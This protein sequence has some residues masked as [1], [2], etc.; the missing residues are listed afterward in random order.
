MV[1]SLFPYNLPVKVITEFQGRFL[2]YISYVCSRGNIILDIYLLLTVVLSKPKKQTWLDLD[3]FL[4]QN[5]RLVA[6]F[7]KNGK[8]LN[9]SLDMRGRGFVCINSIYKIGV[10]KSNGDIAFSLRPTCQGH[11]RISRFFLHK[12]SYVYS[13]D[14]SLILTDMLSRPQNMT[15]FTLTRF[16][17]KMTDWRPS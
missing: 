3:T 10:Y 16:T 14:T 13:L 1:T 8:I 5:C 11:K 15:L 2:R 7:G 17:F 9:I 6:I 12:Y 4:I